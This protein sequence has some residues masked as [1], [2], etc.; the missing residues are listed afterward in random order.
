MSFPNKNYQN[1]NVILWEPARLGQNGVPH[2]LENLCPKVF[3]Q[4]KVSKLHKISVVLSTQVKET[5]YHG[6]AW[7][8]RSTKLD[9]SKPN[10]G[11]VRHFLLLQS[12]AVDTQDRCDMPVSL[13]DSSPCE[14]M[15]LPVQWTVHTTAPRSS[16]MHWMT[17]LNP[18]EC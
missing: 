9:G 10:N 5:G 11:S 8:I 17:A 6:L 3:S 16:R 13:I 1:L 18:L 15:P 4:L 2:Q 12:C 14:V 7:L